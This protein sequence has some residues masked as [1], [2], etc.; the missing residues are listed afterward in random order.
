MQ[1]L[2]SRAAWQAGNKEANI[3]QWT[4]LD[5]EAQEQRLK[6][7]K[8]LYESASRDFEYLLGQDAIGILEKLE[9]GYSPVA[10]Q[11]RMVS[12]Y[13]KEREDQAMAAHAKQQQELHG[14]S[15]YPSVGRMPA[16]WEE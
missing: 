9:V 1:E 14:G 3:L 2:S 5:P 6:A 12:R 13:N 15:G 8:R 4:G 7:T 16:V 11:H 10:N